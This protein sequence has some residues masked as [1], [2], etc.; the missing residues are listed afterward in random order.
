MVIMPMILIIITFNYYTQPGPASYEG[1]SLRRSRHPPHSLA[2]PSDCVSVSLLLHLSFFFF[3]LPSSFL[4]LCFIHLFPAVSPPI[5][6]RQWVKEA[7]H[8]V[9]GRPANEW[10]ET[11]VNCKELWDE[12]W[13]IHCTDCTD[14]IPFLSMCPPP[15]SSSSHHFFY[16][17]PSLL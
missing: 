6:R 11:E 5:G 14:S 2:E 7:A 13:R 4:G 15:P 12:L 16:S 1:S 17:F 9:E 10:G 3:F 8:A